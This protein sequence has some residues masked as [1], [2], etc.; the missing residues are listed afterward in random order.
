MT[1]HQ[2]IEAL[3]AQLTAATELNDQAVIIKEILGQYLRLRS[4]DGLPYTDRLQALADSMDSDHYRAW[5]LFHR[6]FAI[7]MSGDYPTA[8]RLAQQALE[9]FLLEQNQMAVA[10]SYNSI[11]NT[12]QVQGSYAEALQNHIRA[13]QIREELGDKPGIATSLSNIAIIYESLGNDVEA[14]KNNRRALQIAKDMGAK[15]LMANAYLNIGNVHLRMKDYDEALRNYIEAKKIETASANEFGIAN[16]QANSGIV[17]RLRGDY[18]EAMRNFLPAMEVYRAAGNRQGYALVLNSIAT[19]YYDQGKY[20]EAV[21]AFLEALEITEEI[22]AKEESAEAYDILWK[23]YRIRGDHE[24]ALDYFEK[25]WKID[26]EMSGQEAQR[27]LSQLNFQHEIDLQEKEA[28]LLKEKN[29]TISIYAHKLEV[30]N[31]SLHQFAHVA[32]HDLREP[33]RMVSSYMGLLEKTLGDRIDPVQKQFIGFAVDGARRMEQLILDLL[34]LAKVDADP[35]I[36]QVALA[37][38]VDEVRSNLEVLLREKNADIITSALPVITADRSQI[39]QLFQ[40]IIGN[41][42]KYNENPAPLITIGFTQADTTGILSIADNG[43]GIPA[44]YREK[45]FQIFKRVPTEKKYEGSGIGLAICK[46]IVDGLGGEIG[47][48]DNPSGGTVFQIT[49]PISLI[50]N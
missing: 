30:S 28:R 14:L 47:I 5:V 36:E 1:I 9:I 13:L 11:A 4:S 22:G 6:S 26:K 21:A 16:A 18:E 40:N 29:E 42:I 2:E 43:I 7:R 49:I 50:E 24:K 10:A 35:K 37:S 48:E 15:Q 34:R 44:E 17:Y 33:L 12:Y 46:K 45:A 3:K 19:T 38:I 41:G 25:Y 31:N 8:R 27:Q 20:D 23:I 39:M 32:S